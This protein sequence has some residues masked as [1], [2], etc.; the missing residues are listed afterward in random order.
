MFQ[1][2]VQFNG[3]Y[4]CPDYLIEGRSIVTSKKGH[5]LIYP[6]NYENT[7]GHEKLR[8]HKSF[9]SIAKQVEKSTT[10][11]GKIVPQYGLKGCSWP[12]VF[13]KFDIVRGAAIDYMH[14]VLIGVL[15]MLMKLWF[16][17]SHRK[18]DWFMGGYVQEIDQ[19]MAA[20][21]PPIVISRIPRSIANDLKHWKASEYRS[22]LLVYGVIAL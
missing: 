18:A 15:R 7:C 3:Y 4:G 6:F 10:E 5:K 12:M 19:R 21:E 2:M 8:D 14:L 13:P 11:T 17:Q 9:V 20:V 1:N 16:D 22:F